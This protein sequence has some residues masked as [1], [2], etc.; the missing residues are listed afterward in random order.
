MASF[1][2]DLKERKA[3][4]PYIKT[5]YTTSYKSLLYFPKQ[6]IDE[7]APA[8]V[9]KWP[10]ILFLHGAGERGDDFSDMRTKGLPALLDK[11][12]KFPFVVVSPQCGFYDYWDSKKLHK[13]LEDIKK[14][15][16]VDEDRIYGTG[17]SM[18]GFGIW[19]MACDYPNL[20]AAIVPICG[21]GETHKAHL[22]KQLP[23]WAFHGRGDT[24]V[25]IAN[26]FKM[27]SAMKTAGASEIKFTE[28]PA[29]NMRENHEH[30]D[31]WTPT[32]DNIE[33]Y[34]W[35]LTQKRQSSTVQPSQ[36][37][38]SAQAPQSESSSQEQQTAQESMQ[39][40][41]LAAITYLRSQINQIG[42]ASK[43][44]VQF[45]VEAAVNG[46]NERMVVVGSIP[47]LG[48]GNPYGGQK[49]F[50]NKG[51]IWACEVIVNKSEGQLE[52]HYALA[53]S[54]G[55]VIKMRETLKRPLKLT[56]APS[57]VM[58]ADLWGMQSK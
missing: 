26:S 31:S 30:H 21:G 39:P 50:W 6:Y 22:I 17:F 23:T 10:L 49:M 18:G 54:I 28:Y 40:A 36:Q 25:P 46:P 1:F 15:V 42:V 16:R 12:M 43:V 57:A 48:S 34:H 5:L 38:Q 32:Y 52:Y 24:I 4:E 53:S 27:L 41:E 58:T 45:V 51:N 9:T 29:I 13:L 11:E 37:K 7:S 8:S 14:Q 44:R 47:L 20:F 35:M 19:R 2:I 33:V 3:E 55:N 56:D